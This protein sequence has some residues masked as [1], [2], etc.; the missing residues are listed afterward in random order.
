MANELDAHLDEWSLAYVGNPINGYV[1]IGRV[2]GRG[3]L[4]DG[5]IASTSPVKFMAPDL[6]HA[7]TSSQLRRYDLGRA[8]PL[9]LKKICVLA[10]TLAVFWRLPEQTVLRLDVD[11]VETAGRHFGELDG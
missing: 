10:T 2:F 8:A 9:T 5:N 7:I 4:T 11:P 1:L 6:S 3:G